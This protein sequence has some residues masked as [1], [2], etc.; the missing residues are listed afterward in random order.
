[1]IAKNRTVVE[2][3]IL[4][5]RVENCM[6]FSSCG[7]LCWQSCQQ[8]VDIHSCSLHLSL[9]YTWTPLACKWRLCQHCFPCQSSCL[10]Y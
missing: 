4:G 5:T 1:V 6:H 10:C 7:F 9:S 2:M 3:L 8:W